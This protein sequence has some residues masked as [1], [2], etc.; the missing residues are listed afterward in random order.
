MEQRL[1]L[2]DD[3]GFVGFGDGS[4]V[5]A[6]TITIGVRLRIS[7]VRRCRR[8]LILAHSWSVGRI[9]LMLLWIEESAGGDILRI[10]AVPSH[11]ADSP[12]ASCG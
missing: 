10:S 7:C 3:F 12:C 1:A 2:A 8:S 5:A 11:A 6:G 4:A 9:M